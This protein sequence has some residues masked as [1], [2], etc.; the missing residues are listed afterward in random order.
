MR[1]VLISVVCIA[2]GVMASNAQQQPP[3]SP[4]T[5]APQELFKRLAPSVFV[6]EA[7]DKS[8]A[9]VATGSGVALTADK[10]VTN[11]HVVNS[12]TSVRVSQNSR[13]WPAEIVHRDADHDICGLKIENLGATPVRIR[14]STDI[15]IGEP[16]YA[17]GA[18]RGLELTLSEGIISSIR[19]VG[20]VNLVL[21]TTAPISPGSSGGGLFD[22]GGRLIGITS[23]QFK[24]SQ[25]LNFAIPAEIASAGWI[26]DYP[27]YSTS[28][29]EPPEQRPTQK[30][31]DPKPDQKKIWTDAESALM[32]ARHDNGKPV[33]WNQATIFCSN[34]NLD[35][36]TDWRLPTLD[37]LDRFYVQG[38]SQIKGFFTPP[39]GPATLLRGF[40]KRGSSSFQMVGATPTLLMAAAMN[41]R[42]AFG[43]SEITIRALGLS[44]YSTPLS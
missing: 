5:V 11:C 15:E 36:Y 12:G 41:E 32:W 1:P 24:D 8:G 42:C 13:S 10:V 3:L 17:L 43:P 35:G 21:Q 6:V 26:V 44:R 40:P 23:F 28:E 29:A 14:N 25:N 20:G 30:Q 37:E 9:I 2:W 34:S 19:G 31:P 7:T 38:R 33:T 16:A 39:Y 22:A 27:I 18:P 4:R